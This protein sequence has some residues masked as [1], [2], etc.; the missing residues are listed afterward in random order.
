[1]LVK[2][3]AKIF[4]KFFKARERNEEKAKLTRAEKRQIWKK[5][6]EKIKNT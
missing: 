4:S 6:W 5:S 2:I 1:M 3:I